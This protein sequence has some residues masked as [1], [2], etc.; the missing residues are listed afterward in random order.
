MTTDT[1]TTT[2][3]KPFDFW[4][5]NNSKDWAVIPAGTIKGFDEDLPIRLQV[6]N[7]GF[8]QKHIEFRHS[9]WLKKITKTV[10]EALATKLGQS[11]SIYT[12]EEDNKLKIMMRVSPDSLLVIRHV[13]NRQGNFF[14]VVS[15]YYKNERVDG[16]YV[17]RYESKF[18]C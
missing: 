9:H 16:D 14:T 4:L 15:L 3:D 12:T 5:I 6:G 11:G 13:S 18:K 2:G 1:F 17:G 10:Q 8:G 7:K